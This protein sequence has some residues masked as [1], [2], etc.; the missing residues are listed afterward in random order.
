MIK[1]FFLIIKVLLRSKIVFKEPKKNKLVVF[2]KESSDELK[3]IIKDKVYFLMRNRSHQI[4]KI[5]LTFGLIKRFIKNYNGNLMTSYLVSLLEVIKPKVVLTFIDNSFKFS[6]LAKLLEKKIKFIAIQNAYRFD[7][8]ENDYL[9]KKKLTNINLNRRL[10]S[11]NLLCLGQHDVDIYKKY[12]IKLKK[13]IKVGSLRLANALQYIKRNKVKLKLFR[14]DVCVISDTTSKAH[15][16]NLKRKEKNSGR[17][18]DKGMADTVQYAVRY[19]MKHKKKF[20]FAIKN[21]EI[22][23][24]NQKEELNFYKKYLTNDEYNFL[25]LNINKNRTGQYASY[26]AM[27]QSRVT[28]S[29]ISTMLG[30]NLALGGKILACNFTKLGILDFPIKG[31]CFTKNANYSKFEKK[32]TNI[33]LTSK[34][35]YFSKLKERRNYIIN[36]NKKVS[37]I[38][39]I[40]NEIKQALK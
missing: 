21:K 28:V 20:I 37:T 24:I 40:E 15:F 1:K 22:G 2:D 3:P 4:N 29:S 12:K 27:F 26:I 18:L 36:Y 17:H 13:I 25:I 16:L 19:C 8:I 23:Q 38:Q 6:D 5:Y 35:K 11:P 7:I 30:E 32:L 39:M 31:I 33:F 9:F 10:Y 34:K 14:Y